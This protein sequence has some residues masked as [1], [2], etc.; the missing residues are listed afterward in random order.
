LKKSFTTNTTKS[1]TVNN[2]IWFPCH[3]K[4][5]HVTYRIVYGS[6]KKSVPKTQ[7][8]LL[9]ALVFYFILFYFI[10]KFWFLNFLLDFRDFW[11]VWN[12]RQKEK[13]KM[14]NC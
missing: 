11:T 3:T 10:S 13:Y 8:I 2:D 14:L 1:K 7:T 9:L 4:I 12:F 5:S 6:L